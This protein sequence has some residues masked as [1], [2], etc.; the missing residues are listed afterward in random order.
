MSKKGQRKPQWK[1][2]SL[3]VHPDHKWVARPNSRVFV[4][5]RGAVRIDFPAEWIVRPAE[6]CI[7]F[8]DKEPPDDNFTLAVSYLRLPP[9]D[10]SRLPLADLVQTAIQ[11]D[12][13]GLLNLSEIFE[14]KRGDLEYAW[15]EGSFV[16]PN[17]KRKAFTRLCIARG[18]LIQ[19]LITLDFWPED[20]ARLLPA[21]DDI[22]DSLRLGHWIKDPTR[23]E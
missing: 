6:D 19:A 23:G 12:D 17:E 14:V 18:N 22:L 15:L 3:P 4:A 20:R 10:W 7:K 11:G 21:W 9:M 1:H 13:R 16:D 8:M 5:D 2:Q